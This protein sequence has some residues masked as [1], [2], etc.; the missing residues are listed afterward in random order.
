MQFQNIFSIFTRISY[1]H[2]AKQVLQIPEILLFISHKAK[3]QYLQSIRSLLI[4]PSVK[5]E[6]QHQLLKSLITFAS[7]NILLLETFKTLTDHKK[8]LVKT[9]GNF[10]KP[11]LEKMEKP[12]EKSSKVNKFHI[13]RP[14]KDPK[15]DFQHFFT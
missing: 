4:N 14:R 3:L 8:I 10:N 1:K 11:L 7:F 12:V 9:Q 6:F 5:S 2:A 13:Q 15:I